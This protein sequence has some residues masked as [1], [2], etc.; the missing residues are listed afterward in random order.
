MKPLVRPHTDAAGGQ[1]FTVT[2]RFSTPQLAAI[3]Y[4]HAMTEMRRGHL[5][6]Y[7]HGDPNIGGTH[8]SAVSINRLEVLRVARLLAARDGQDVQLD[9]RLIEGLCVRRARIV[10]EAARTDQPPGRIKIRHPGRGAYLQADGT[11]H[12]TNP[13]QG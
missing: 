11:M 5:G 6:I 8:I 4:Q 9:P 1:W 3:A 2:A 13:G 12:E 10:T 7:R